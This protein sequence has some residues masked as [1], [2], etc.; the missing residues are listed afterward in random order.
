[1]GYLRRMSH[2][3]DLA[4]TLRIVGV[5]VAIGSSSVAIWLAQKSAAASRRSRRDSLRQGR[6]YAGIGR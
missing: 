4:A 2:F 5:L 1:M 3:R 6:R